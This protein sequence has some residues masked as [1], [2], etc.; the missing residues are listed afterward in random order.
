MT[1]GWVKNGATTPIALSGRSTAH[2]RQGWAGSRAPRCLE[3]P[4]ARVDAHRRGSVQDAGHRADADPGF[5][6]YLR[7]GQTPHPSSPP[8]RTASMEAVPSC[9]HCQ[10]PEPYPARPWHSDMVAGRRA[11]PGLSA[12]VRGLRRRRDR[13]PAR[14]SSRVSTTSSGS[15]STGSG[16]ARRCRRPNADWGYD[17][18]DYRGVHPD[19]GTLEDLDA[20]VAE[21]GARG[22]RVLLD[23]VPNHT[24]DRHPWFVDALGGR[25][26]AHRDWYVWADPEPTAGR[27]TTGVSNFGGS[28]WTLRRADGPVLPAQLPARASPTSTGGTTDV[29]EAFDDIL[30]FWFDRGVAGFRIDVCHAIVKD[31]ELR[32]DPPPSR[33][34]TRRISKRGLR[35]VLLDEPPGGPRRAAALARARRR[36]HGP[37]RVL[38]GE[39]YVLDLEQLIPFYGEGDDELHLAF[40]FLFVHCR[41]RRGAAARDR[42]GRRGASCPTAAWPV[43][44]G[45]NHDA[46]RLA[47]R[48]A[49]GDAARARAALLMLLDAARDAVPLLRRRDRAARRAARPGGRARP[50][51]A[52]HGRPEREPR[53]LPD[54]DAVD[55]RARRRLHRGRGDAVA[56][57]RRPGGAQRRRAARGPGLGRC[58]SCAT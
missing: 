19:L 45:S 38:V 24:S 29:R 11:V 39:T 7:D 43:W 30:R 8:R 57:V 1:E 33:T 35:Q 23:L 52:A 17:V 9:H 50:G 28:A 16:S 37:G 6:G 14:A 47:T 44:T 22:I 34:T 18:A 13:R 46:G 26:A 32:D 54:A 58:T 55:R 10:A 12:L 15:A 40:N 51:G 49:G 48:W 27:R 5:C 2:V 42:R 41:P 53:R 31:R 20:L 25:D 3:H 56:A 4:L 36:A 21:A